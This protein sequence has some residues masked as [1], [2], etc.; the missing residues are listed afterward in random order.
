M[1]EIFCGDVDSLVIFVIYTAVKV[2][3]MKMQLVGDS[4]ITRVKTFRHAGNCLTYL[5]LSRTPRAQEI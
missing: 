1:F 2:E 5:R 4:G 3:H